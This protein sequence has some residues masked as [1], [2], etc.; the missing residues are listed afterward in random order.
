[1]RVGLVDVDAE[2]RGR[3]T[4]PNLPLMKIAAYHKMLGDIVEWYQ[5]LLSGHMDIVYL[6]RVFGDE[7]T[8]DY[9]WP[10]DADVVI[11]GGSGYAIKVEGE[12]EVHHKELDPPLPP[13]IECM[14]PDYS[15]Y[16][17]KGIT[18]TAYGFLTRGCP[19]GCFFCHE[20]S[21]QG[22]Q[23]KTVARLTDFWSGQRHISLM[24]PNLTC[25]KDWGMHIADLANSGATVDFTQGLDITAMS[26]AKCQDLNGIKYKRIHFA[27][28]RP[29]EDNTEK[30]RMVMDNLKG[31][32]KETIS[33]YVLTNAGSTHEE[34]LWRVYTLRD[35]GIQPYVMIYRKK[36]APKITRKLQRYCN[37]PQIFWS[38]PSFAEYQR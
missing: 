27:W 34:D 16:A 10:I 23:V 5:P 9:N 2:S 29:W 6:S 12:S 13:E 22:R 24:D 26:S 17:D 8:Q 38:T 30:F 20:C 1:M 18:D 14:M 36:T 31:A 3:V 25:S 33:A 37:S 28:D 11:R 21:M 4:F 35:L 32:R 7:Y 15:I 19:R